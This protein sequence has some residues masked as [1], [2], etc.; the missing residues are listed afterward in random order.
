MTLKPAEPLGSK[1]APPSTRSLAAPGARLNVAVPARAV[2][3][4]LPRGP[5]KSRM[6]Y[7][8]HARRVDA[9]QG[10]IVRELEQLGVRVWAIGRPCDLLTRFRGLWLPLEVKPLDP[11]NRNRR[12][13]DEQKQF[14]EETGTPVVRTAGEAFDRIQEHWRR[15]ARL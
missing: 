7:W 8:R 11:H 10:E 5:A 3:E 1:P 13:Q 15:Y 2:R 4:R 14:L 6:S 9:N 12:D